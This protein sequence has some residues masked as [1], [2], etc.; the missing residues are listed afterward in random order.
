MINL[1]VAHDDNYGIGFEGH[2]PWPKNKADFQ[3]FKRLTMGNYVVVGRVTWEGMNVKSLPGRKVYVCG[4]S[5]PRNY[6]GDVCHIWNAYE[7]VLYAEHDKKDLFVIG[8]RQ[9]YLEFMKSYKINK[10]YTTHIPGIFMC[11]TFLPEIEE[12]NSGYP[13]VEVNGMFKDFYA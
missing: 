1:I 7:A 3:R 5:K 8:G 9:I 10:V 4:L 13:F 2:L 11:D 12:F 6:D